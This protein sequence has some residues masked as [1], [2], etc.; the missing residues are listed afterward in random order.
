MFDYQFNMD[1][2][3]KDIKDIECGTLFKMKDSKRTLL[4]VR[5]HYCNNERLYTNLITGYT[6]TRDGLLSFGY[7]FFKKEDNEDFDGV[8]VIGNIIKRQI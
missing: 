7:S 4:I 1:K 8:E 6:F 2:G 5:K 3:I